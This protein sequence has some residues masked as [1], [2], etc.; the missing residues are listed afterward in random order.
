MNK[1]KYKEFLFEYFMSSSR[2]DILKYI[3][4]DIRTYSNHD[5]YIMMRAVSPIYKD[6]DTTMCFFIRKNWFKLSVIVEINDGNL[7]S[8]KIYDCGRFSKDKDKDYILNIWNVSKSNSIELEIKNKNFTK[9]K[10]RK[11]KID[12]LK[13]D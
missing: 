2:N 8:Y 5:D 7:H 12:K 10:L 11:L 13:I 4:K 6:D 3:N 1:N 9:N